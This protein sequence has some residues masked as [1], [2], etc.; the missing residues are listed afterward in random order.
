MLTT[1]YGTVPL[2]PISRTVPNDASGGVRGYDICSFGT[3]ATITA[4][5]QQN[6]PAYGWTLVSTSG[7]IQSWKSSSGT[8]NW[9]VT[10]P[11]DWNINW[12]VP[13]S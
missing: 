4:F 9:S 2:P 5:L 11:L 7:G 12:R 13:L 6:L 10:D 8:I 3:A 1:A